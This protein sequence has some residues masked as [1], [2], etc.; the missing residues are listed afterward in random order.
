M[1]S[2]SSSALGSPLSGLATAGVDVSGSSPPRWRHS[3]QHVAVRARSP[4]PRHATEPSD[5][6]PPPPLSRGG[7]PGVFLEMLE[8]IERRLGDLPRAVRIRV[9]R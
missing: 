8:Q 5:R 1:S 9:E 6:R 7:P 3:D 4:P 2:S